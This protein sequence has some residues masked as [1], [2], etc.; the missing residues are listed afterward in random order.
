VLSLYGKRYQE[1]TDAG[2][3]I[4]ILYSILFMLLSAALDNDQHEASIHGQG[5]MSAASAA[6][7]NVVNR[8]VESV[9]GD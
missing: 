5:F 7:L 4:R 8:F 3:A 2:R 1:G 9:I 6:R